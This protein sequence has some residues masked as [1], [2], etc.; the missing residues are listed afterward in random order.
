MKNC[1]A[2]LA[3]FIILL[4]SGCGTLRQ[5]NPEGERV[6]LYTSYPTQSCKFLGTITNSNVHEAFG[7]QQ[8]LNMDTNNYLRNEGAK[9]GANVVVL[10]SH[11]SREFRRVYSKALYPRATIINAHAV[12]AKAYR[13]PLGKMGSL[14]KDNL[15]IEKTSVINRE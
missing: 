9:L 2:L 5:L 11:Q 10:V 4:I 3:F 13:C 14:K 12:N 6:R 8:E 15:K 1:S 7:N